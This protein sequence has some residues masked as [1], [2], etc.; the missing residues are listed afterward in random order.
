MKTFDATVIVLACLTF[1]VHGTALVLPVCTSSL[2]ILRGYGNGVAVQNSVSTTR[3]L[4]TALQISSSEKIADG[5]VP[6]K[7][8]NHVGKKKLTRASA[9]DLSYIFL[10]NVAQSCG[11]PSLDKA[12]VAKV[13]FNDR[14]LGYF[15]GSTHMYIVY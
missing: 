15:A 6:L 13:F 10:R 2:R 7:N 9:W 1:I 4:P 14:G 12:P 3:R 5:A 8:N 11:F